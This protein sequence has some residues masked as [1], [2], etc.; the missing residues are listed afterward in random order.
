MNHAEKLTPKQEKM[1]RIIAEIFEMSDMSTAEACRV[2]EF[3]VEVTSRSQLKKGDGPRL[4]LS[5]RS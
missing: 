2:L 1:A 5:M 3:L 4:G